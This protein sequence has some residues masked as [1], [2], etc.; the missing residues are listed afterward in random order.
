MSVLTLKVPRGGEVP[1]V[2]TFGTSSAR[3]AA[4][5]RVA[6]NYL[7][8]PTSHQRFKRV[9]FT[10]LALYRSVKKNRPD[11]VRSCPNLEIIVSQCHNSDYHAHRA[12]RTELPRATNLPPALPACGLH[13]LCS[14]PVCR[15]GIGPIRITMR[16]LNL[17]Q[18]SLVIHQQ[19]Y[20]YRPRASVSPL[21]PC[22]NRGS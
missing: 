20:W 15:K 22:V 1:S 4:S 14:V 10:G 7:E 9:F 16:N 13:R 8:P 6:L 17:D 3:P 11:T 5:G 2:V 12:S 18:L 19:Q 21:I